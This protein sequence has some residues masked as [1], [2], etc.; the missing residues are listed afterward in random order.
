M[1]FLSRQFTASLF[2]AKSFIQTALYTISITACFENRSWI[3]VFSFDRSFVLLK[4]LKLSL[5]EMALNFEV[6]DLSFT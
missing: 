5:V 4:H 3:D 6:L 1:Q 2:K